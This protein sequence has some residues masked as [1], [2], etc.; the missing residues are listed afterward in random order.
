MVTHSTSEAAT[1]VALSLRSDAPIWA[2]RVK[3]LEHVTP[4]NYEQGMTQQSTNAG[5]KKHKKSNGLAI[6]V[7]DAFVSVV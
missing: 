3:I 1:L 4:D 5:T 6:D 2:P 7:G